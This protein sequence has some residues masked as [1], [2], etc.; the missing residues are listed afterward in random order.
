MRNIFI[1]QHFLRLSD[2][3]KVEYL[4]LAYA[5][6]IP[7]NG[8]TFLGK[9]VFSL[10]SLQ[11]EQSPLFLFDQNVIYLR[12]VDFPEIKSDANIKSIEKK[13][14]EIPDGQAKKEW[15]QAFWVE[16]KSSKKLKVRFKIALGKMLGAPA[17]EIPDISEV[18]GKYKDGNEARLL[19]GQ[20]IE[21][22]DKLNIGPYVSV[23][24][25]VEIAILKKLLD[26]LDRDSILGAM[27]QFLQPSSWHVQNRLCMVSNFGKNISRYIKQEVKKDETEYQAILDKMGVS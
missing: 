11:H 24:E 14:L 4:H 3:H 20:Y 21:K 17:D 10:F 8:L 26:H 13:L 23:N 19:Y 22:Y 12:N 15:S 16:T 6:N 5:S 7:I 27:D 25:Y 18:W 2:R 1:D 9:K